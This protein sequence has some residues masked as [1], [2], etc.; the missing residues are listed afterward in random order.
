MVSRELPFC[1]T[2]NEEYM[3]CEES[4][5]CLHIANK[6]VACHPEC[7]AL[8]PSESRSAFFEATSYAYQPPQAEDERRVRWLRSTW[9]SILY[10]TYPLPMELCEHIAQYCLQPFA[11][12]CG[13]ALWETRSRHVAPSHVSFST[14][15]WARFTLFEGLSYVLSLTNEQPTEHDTGANGTRAR[16][17]FDPESAHRRTAMFIAEDHIGAREVLFAPSPKRPTIKGR[18]IKERQNIWW[19]SCAVP[20]PDMDINCTRYSLANSTY[21]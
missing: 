20:R 21:V 14:E 16:L 19:Q 7:L 3:F 18:P 2:T 10:G 1:A 4:G 9:S 5:R 15:L 6:A 12:L 8:V 17:A 11:V 13:L